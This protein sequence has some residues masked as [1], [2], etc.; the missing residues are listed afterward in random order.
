M[1]HLTAIV[2][3][4]DE[5]P[6][7][8]DNPMPI[9]GGLSGAIPAGTNVIGH[10]IEDASASAGGISLSSRL[11][12]SAAS[13]NAANVKTSAG[14]IYSA[15]GYNAAAYTVYLVLYDAVTNPPVP[16]TTAIRKK[17]PIPAGVAFAL[18]WPVGMSFAN[19]IGYAFTK[20]PADNDITALAAADILQFNLDYI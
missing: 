17:I 14:R 1:T 7:S 11:A 10:V 12:S 4:R 19:G 2:V 18:D 16:G 8:S 9:T 5:K 13:T 15:Q 6:V 20:L 3:G